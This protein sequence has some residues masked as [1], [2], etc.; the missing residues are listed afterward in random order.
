[1]NNSEIEYKFHLP[2]ELI[3]QD[4]AQRRGDSRLLLVEPETGIIGETVFRNLPSF[5]R[6]GDLLVMNES[7]VMP[8]RIMTK[9]AETAGQVEILL[10][11]PLDDRPLTWL[12]MARPAKRL[13]EGIQLQ[14]VKVAILHLTQT[15][16]KSSMAD[17][18]MV[19]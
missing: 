13:R 16:L 2:E 18:T 7:R 1:M 12:A 9:R 5:L 4:P 6:K 15:I 8:A 19:F 11:R 14:V 10:V 17:H 3:A